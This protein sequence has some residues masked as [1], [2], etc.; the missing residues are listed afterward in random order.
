M[1]ASQ[2]HLFTKFFVGDLP[3]KL[4]WRRSKVDSVLH[5]C[6][7]RLALRGN[8]YLLPVISYAAIRPY[9]SA[10]SRSSSGRVGQSTPMGEDSTSGDAR[11]VILV[12]VWRGQRGSMCNLSLSVTRLASS[13]PVRDQ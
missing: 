7:N 10:F 1:A 11:H 2:S 3:P 9:G 6:G 4:A 8:Y 13:R 12:A 5:D